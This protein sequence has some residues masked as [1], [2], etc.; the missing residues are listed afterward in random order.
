MKKLLFLLLF[1]NCVLSQV[2]INTVTPTSTLDVNG[3][4]TIDQKNFG[5]YGGLLIKG[6]S[7]F[8][9][10]PN[11]TFSTLNNSGNDEIAAYIGG[12]INDN[13]TG[14]EAMDINFLTSTNGLGGLSERMR[15]KDN[16][17]I[18]IGNQNPNAPLQFGNTIA[19]RKIVLWESANNNQQY[20]GFGING[21]TLRYQVDDTAADHIFFAGVNASTSNELMR[22]KGNGNVGIGNPSPSEKLDIAGKIKISDGSQAVDRVLTSDANG[23]GTWKPIGINNISALLGA[24]V[25]VP[26]TTAIFLQTGTSITLPPG[27]YAVNVTML[28]TNPT[29]S[30]TPANSSFWVR[31]TFSD[32]SAANPLTSL[33]IVGST[34][35]SGNLTGS[36]V[37]SIMNGT[38]IINNNTGVNKTYYYV[39]GSALAI[40]TTDTL[41]AIGGSLGENNIIAYKLQ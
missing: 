14:S 22:I 6:D 11:I 4:V 35:V 25:N 36:S 24:G 17:N 41:F 3:Q 5:G 7:P 21:G 28:L 39:A 16:G 2:G 20:Y 29:N 37:F 18:G 15:I 19:N 9:N 32:S 38:I 40:N 8:A 26:H 13:T 34:L 10:F 33:D 27:R 30:I 31:S 12:V 1:S 23:V